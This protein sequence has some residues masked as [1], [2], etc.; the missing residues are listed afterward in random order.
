M[1]APIRSPRGATISGRQL[2]AAPAHALRAT[3][4][5]P[6]SITGTGG[7]PAYVLI[8]EETFRRL[9]GR[10]VHA[11]ALVDQPLSALEALAD[12]NYREE[13]PDPMDYIPK[14]EVEQPFE[15]DEDE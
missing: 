15:F 4:A 1:N 6:V 9:G 8:S 2:R 11:N 5:G 14:R 10:K 13:D 12:P 7:K 3:A